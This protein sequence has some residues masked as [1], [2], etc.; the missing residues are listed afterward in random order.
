[1]RPILSAAAIAMASYL[2]VAGLVGCAV[3]PDF[4]APAAPAVTGFTPE[5]T[6][7]DTAGTNGPHGVSQ[8]FITDMDIP[9]QWWRVFHSEPLNRLIEQAIAANPNLA[10]A[11]AAL[12]QA[13]ENAYAQRGSYFPIVTGAFNASRNLTPTASETPFSI[14]GSPY[15]T[16][17]TPQLNVSFVPDVFGANRRAVESLTALARNEEFQLEATYLTLT[18][19]VVTG[20]IQEASLRGQIA[21]TLETVRVESRLLNILRRQQVLGQA[22]GADVA[23]QEAALA[24]AQ[25]TLPPLQKQLAQQRDALT[26]L[27]GH[28]PSEAIAAT[29]QLEDLALPID[30]PVSLPSKLVRQRP[31]VRAAEEML[32]SA[33]ALIGQAVAARLPQII[34]TGDIGNSPTASGTFLVPGTNFW[35]IAGGITTPL[36]DFGTLLHKQRAARA[37]F[38]QA[39][40]QYRATVL[41]AF[42]NVTD[43]LHALQTDA[44]ALASATAAGKAAA[45]SLSIVQRQLALGQ[46]A[47]LAL[48]N[49]QNAYQQVRLALVQADANRLADTAALFQALG[50]GWWNLTDDQLATQG[51]ST[52]PTP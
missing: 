43:A 48:L 4:K 44:N 9:A 3:G 27:A 39:G 15:Y 28:F 46:V 35:T 22:A 34:L 33:S 16:L 2:I 42:Q 51:I 18:A 21:A 19:N 6:L 13:Q 1:M 45:R 23:A 7:P 26:V 31:D 30:L 38:E 5:K 37:A 14:T 20:V 41:S 47:Y 32:H 12:R 10:A 11:Q 50:G 17:I 36:F 49:A 25:L 40:A 24:Q 29:F 8:H 52:S